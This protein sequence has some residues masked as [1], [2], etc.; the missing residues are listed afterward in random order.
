MDT[1]RIKDELS[2]LLVPLQ[3]SVVIGGDATDM[4]LSFISEHGLLR[5]QFTSTLFDTS[6]Q[7]LERTGRFEH[8]GIVRILERALERVHEERVAV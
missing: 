2:I 3:I 4:R 7:F 5:V 1:H 8:P 6:Y